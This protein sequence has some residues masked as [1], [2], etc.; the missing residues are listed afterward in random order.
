MQHDQT[1]LEAELKWKAGQRVRKLRTKKRVRIYRSQLVTGVAK[2]LPFDLTLKIEQTASPTM[3]LAM[4]PKHRGS[5]TSTDWNHQ[6]QATEKVPVIG[7]QAAKWNN[8]LIRQL[9]LTNQTVQ[10]RSMRMKQEIQGS[11]TGWLT[12]GIV[13]SQNM[14][15]KCNSHL[16]ETIVRTLDLH[17]FRPLG[18][19]PG[20]T[21]KRHISLRPRANLTNRHSRTYAT[22]MSPKAMTILTPM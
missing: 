4:P 6:Q 18:E 5:L 15:A 16:T 1:K 8:P 19:I 13:T 17:L 12:F 14:L 10:T 9:N 11:E 3:S 7:R 21:A 2:N 22:Q 20:L